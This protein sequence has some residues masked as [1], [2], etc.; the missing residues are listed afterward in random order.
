MHLISQTCNRE[1]R[2]DRR[3]HQLRD[4]SQCLSFPTRRTRGLDPTGDPASEAPWPRGAREAARG[5]PESRRG[6][7]AGGG[8]REELGGL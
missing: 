7:G 4:P 1:G 8:E 2:G 3:C 5:L 6:G